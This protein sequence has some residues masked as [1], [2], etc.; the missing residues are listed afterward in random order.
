MRKRVTLLVG[1][2][3]LLSACGTASQQGDRPEAGS[4]GDVGGAGLP[5]IERTAAIYAAVV[6]QLVTEDHT[7]GAAAS[8]FKRVYIIDGVVAK[9][10]DPTMP[11]YLDVRARFG[12]ALKSRLLRSLADLPPV[13]F[14]TDTRDVVVDR[15][16]CP[17][18]K[19]DGV[20]LSLGP[21]SGGTRRVTV[22]NGLFFA[23][24][25]GQWLTYVVESKDSAWAVVGTK[26]PVAIS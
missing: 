14:V 13:E 4:D 9:A 21:I 26:G 8:P 10:N 24:L 17:S 16:D 22:A 5:H 7:F 11:A 19:A 18:V 23:C 2:A 1:I 15:D 6:R 20:L 3:L 25:G 12:P